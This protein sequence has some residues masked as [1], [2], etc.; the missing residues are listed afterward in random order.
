MKERIGDWMQTYTGRQFWPLD[1]RP[2]D[3]CLEDIF[4]ALSN[5]ARFG[6]HA[7]RFY[8]VGEH[9]LLVMA[10]APREL[11]REALLH[12][13]AEA[14]IGDM[15]RPLKRDMPKFQDA[16]ARIVVAIGLAVGLDLSPHPAIHKADN[17]ALAIEKRDLLNQ[18]PAPWQPLPTPPRWLWIARGQQQ[19][20]DTYGALLETWHLF[21][22]GEGGSQ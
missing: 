6:G 11:A 20:A 8:S 15:V 14:Y 22:V 10:L 3:V 1:P 18:E 7:N 4:W 9:S 13:A 16:E 5:V 17:M 2:E 19:P 12:D 21:S